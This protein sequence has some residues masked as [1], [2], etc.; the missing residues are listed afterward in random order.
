M[1][2]D[3][4]HDRGLYSMPLKPD[5]SVGACSFTGETMGIGISVCY[6]HKGG[7]Y[8]APFQRF[9]DN[10][11]PDI[12][13][14]V[15]YHIVN[16]GKIAVNLHDKAMFCRKMLYFV[17]HNHHFYTQACQVGKNCTTEHAS[18]L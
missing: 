8:T 14:T 1:S 3:S 2:R 10:G 11:M 9:R 6:T 13:R 7:S 18:K 12:K 17:F 4:R 15:F 5:D 16:M